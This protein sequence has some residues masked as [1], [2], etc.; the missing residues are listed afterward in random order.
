MRFVTLLVGGVSLGAAGCSAGLAQPH[1]DWPTTRVIR[2][3]SFDHD[4]PEEQIK[5]LAED[6]SIYAYVLDVCGQERKYIDRGNTK[7]FQFVDVTN[8]PRSSSQA[9]PE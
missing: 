1:A 7:E 9:A 8:S 3:A 2:T 5:V 4:C 6:E